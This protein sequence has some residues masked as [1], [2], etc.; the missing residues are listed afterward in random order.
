MR[1]SSE[2]ITKQVQQTYDR[3]GVY[4]SATRQK[5]WPEMPMY[6]KKIKP[7]QRVLDLGCGNGRLLTGIRVKIDYIGVD[8]SQTMINEAQRLHQGARFTVGD[9]TKPEV[10]RG[11]GKYDV[12]FCVAVLHHIP[13]KEMQIQIFKNI[14]KHLKSG[15]S[16]CL[17]V[18]N[19]WNYKYLRYHLRS[20]RDKL[21][22][23]RW[24]RVPFQKNENRFCFGFDKG[25]LGRLAKLSGLNVRETVYWKK[26]GRKGNFFN[27]A[28]LWIWLE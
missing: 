28:N 9:I 25:Y 14:K 8:F 24:L 15:G 12:I 3:I 18:W 20:W 1:V 7:N 2:S 6:L 5:V 27:G 10:W 16:V 23:W 11:L 19:L 22:N 26:D 13:T 4:F 21:I 17:S